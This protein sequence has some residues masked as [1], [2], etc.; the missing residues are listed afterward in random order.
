MG[1]TD[2]R[3]TT[4]PDTRRSWIARVLPLVLAALLA[5]AAVG[6]VGAAGCDEPG[7]YVDTPDGIALVGGCFSPG[8]IDPMM[9]DPADGDPAARRG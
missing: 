2:T 1:T 7:T 9:G 8:K 3:D 6:T 4:S 5:V